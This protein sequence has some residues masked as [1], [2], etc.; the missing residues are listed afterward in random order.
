[1]EATVA[2]DGKA[3]TPKG[4][5]SYSAA[6]RQTSHHVYL[7]TKGYLRLHR[8]ALQS[9][10]PSWIQQQAVPRQLR[11]AVFYAARERLVNS[12]RFRQR[13]GTDQR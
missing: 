10:A 2:I 13:N 9:E 12:W 1:M 8:D 7:H 5:P 4:W 6:F 3:D 11:K